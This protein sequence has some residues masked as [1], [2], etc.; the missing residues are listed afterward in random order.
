MPKQSAKSRRHV[1]KM[2]TM[3]QPCGKQWQ[4]CGLAQCAVQ[5]EELPEAQRAARGAAGTVP[6]Q[7]AQGAL[8]PARAQRADSRG[9]A[10]EKNK[11]ANAA[12]HDETHQTRR[13]LE[14]ARALT[15][16]RGGHGPPTVSRQLCSQQRRLV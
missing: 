5:Q 10:T 2:S 4:S 16:G 9:D 11:K 12:R 14:T 6:E 7:R 13:A 3:P 8:R 15:A 1:K